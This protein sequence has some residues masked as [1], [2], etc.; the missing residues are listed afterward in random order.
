M[1]EAGVF[2]VMDK[3]RSRN[4]I[5]EDTGTYLETTEQK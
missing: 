3:I 5:G 1:G 4:G 2:P